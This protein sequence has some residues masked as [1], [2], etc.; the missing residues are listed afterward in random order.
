MKRQY[1]TVTSWDLGFVGLASKFL[2]QE[3]SISPGECPGCQIVGYTAA[4]SIS[5]AKDKYTNKT[6]TWEEY[7]DQLERILFDKTGVLALRSDFFFWG[8]GHVGQTIELRDAYDRAYGVVVREGYKFSYL[9]GSKTEHRG[10][11]G[12]E[13]THFFATDGSDFPHEEYVLISKTNVNPWDSTCREGDINTFECSTLCQKAIDGD[14]SIVSDRVNAK[15]CS[16]MILDYCGIKE[17]SG[18]SVCQQA[19]VKKMMET[20]LEDCFL[21]GNERPSQACVD[22]TGNLKNETKIKY[23]LAKLRDYCRVPAN[24]LTK[25]CQRYCRL[26]G[27]DCDA[28]VSTACEAHK[29]KPV[30]ETSPGSLTA[31]EKDSYCSCFNG[32]GMDRLI[33]KNP[34]IVKRFGGRP[35]NICANGLCIDQGYHSKQMVKNREEKTCNSCFVTISNTMEKNS[36]RG[37]VNIDN[38]VTCGSGEENTP[39]PTDSSWE[40]SALYIGIAFIAVVCVLL[41]LRRRNREAGV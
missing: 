37:G 12:P 1:S 2:D 23:D 29:A 9:L 13:I 25:P 38:N 30:D 3:S 26:D 16:S 15:A 21:T 10:L 28:A 19:Y 32:Y 22:V 35:D 7:K 8:Q 17:N 4:R 11:S 33:K 41:V 14:E 40:Q 6:L 20:S 24:A 31:L 36:I 27:T 18:K 5:I 39:A 34:G